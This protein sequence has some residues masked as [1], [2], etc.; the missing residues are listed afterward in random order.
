MSFGAQF[1][2][3]RNTFG[4]QDGDAYSSKIRGTLRHESRSVRDFVYV[5]NSL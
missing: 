3:S 5:F 2:P 4:Q 1:I